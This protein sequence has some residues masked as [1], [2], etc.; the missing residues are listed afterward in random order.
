V[1]K[2]QK[3]IIGRQDF[4]TSFERVAISARTQSGQSKSPQKR[5]LILLLGNVCRGNEVWVGVSPP[6]TT[7]VEDE[8]LR[9]R[10]HRQLK[11]FEGSFLLSLI[12]SFYTP[13]L[14]RSGSILLLEPLLELLLLVFVASTERISSSPLIVLLYPIDLVKVRYQVYDRSGNAYTSLKDA[15]RTIIRE[16]GFS[17]LYQVRLSSRNM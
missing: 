2:N 17:G 15:F 8:W 16:E 14:Y 7:A 12:F 13:L 3:S 4:G 6:I 1:K 9:R 5:N 11:R 10:E